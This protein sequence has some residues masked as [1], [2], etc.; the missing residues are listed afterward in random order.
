MAATASTV[1]LSGVDALC[2][3]LLETAAAVGNGSGAHAQ[4]AASVSR[5]LLHAAHREVGKLRVLAAALQ[6]EMVLLESDAERAR[7][8]VSSSRLPADDEPRFSLMRDQLELV[9]SAYVMQGGALSRA[10]SRLRSL[11]GTDA[12]AL[13][14]VEAEWREA[15]A[16]I[17]RAAA[18]LGEQQ[19]ARLEA[20][21]MLE[22]DLRAERTRMRELKE[23][24]GHALAFSQV[25]AAEL[26]EAAALVARWRAHTSQSELQS[27]QP[28]LQPLAPPSVPIRK[29]A[30]DEAG[31]HEL[32]RQLAEAAQGHRMLRAAPPPPPP[33][34]P[35]PPTLG[36][37]TADGRHHGRGRRGGAPCACLLS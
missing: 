24:L 2:C 11:L 17:V 10:R 33:P 20:V 23:Q 14:A 30:R 29:G 9:T 6:S 22:K 15:D 16:A 37:A 18:Q 12:A 3:A 21:R 35:L 28:P 7:V 13:A 1:H 4:G 8:A 26:A 27:Q 19:R 36:T 25:Q 34:P 32:K 31:H 5:S